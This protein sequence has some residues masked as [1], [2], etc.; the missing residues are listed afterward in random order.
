M[1]IETTEMCFDIT[2]YS[3]TGGELCEMWGWT[4][5]YGN[6]LDSQYLEIRCD[7]ID[8]SAYEG[9]LANVF[10]HR[11]LRPYLGGAGNAPGLVL[12]RV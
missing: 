4:S 7:D 8:G 12:N 1:R 10:D 11:S 2:I 6:N 5:G 9:Y 3:I